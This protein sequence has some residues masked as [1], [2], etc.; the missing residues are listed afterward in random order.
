[1]Q[2]TLQQQAEIYLGTDIEPSEWDEAKARAERKLERII[3]RY[4]DADGARRDEDY[5]AQLVAEAVRDER[6]TRWCM[7]EYDV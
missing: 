3:Y 4:G 6:M 1:M 7:T 5:L 2:I